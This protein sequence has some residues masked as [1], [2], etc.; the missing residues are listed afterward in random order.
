M[1]EVYIDEIS[2]KE[3]FRSLSDR[4]DGVTTDDS[5]NIHLNEEK[6][7]AKGHQINADLEITQFNAYLEEPIR[8]IRRS[9]H[10]NVFVIVYFLTPFQLTNDIDAAYQI[11][12]KKYWSNL[13]RDEVF[14]F[15]GHQEISFIT[16]KLTRNFIEKYN[17]N[18]QNF[19]TQL[20]DTKD[21][22]IIYENISSA[23]VEVLKEIKECDFNNEIELLKLD[24]LTYKLLYN[25]ANKVAY[26]FG[27]QAF[28]RLLPDVDVERVFKVKDY[29]EE[30]FEEKITPEQIAEI[31]QC[32]YSKLRKLFKEV[33]G[34]SILKYT[35]D[36]KLQKAHSW[37]TNGAYNVSDCTYQLGF[38]SMTHFSKLFV[39]KYGC[40][41]SDLK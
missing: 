31:A 20:L 11:K 14:Y 39:N 36:Y 25:F 37:L 22:F 17:V 15:E 3:V 19:T 33:I 2:Y 40:L 8:I 26:R 7:F 18:N 12:N 30:N 6:I 1:R 21:P 16:I 32:S 10:E 28:P 13:K 24:Y 38:S 35:N 27:V 4:F 29:I 5:L 41:P 9:L 34:Q 23:S